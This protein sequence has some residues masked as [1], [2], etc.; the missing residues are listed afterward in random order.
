MVAIASRCGKRRRYT[1]QIARSVERV[2][3][4]AKRPNFLL[5]P[6]RS[7]RWTAPLYAGLPV[8]INVRGVTY[9]IVAQT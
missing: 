4:F 3:G 9:D 1:L 7:A 6:A 2:F 5:N 8:S